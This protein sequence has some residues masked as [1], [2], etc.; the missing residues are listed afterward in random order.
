M[1]GG[2]MGRKQLA[3]LATAKPATKEPEAPKTWG[4]RV[5][6]NFNKHTAI[7]VAEKLFKNSSPKNSLIICM[8]ASGLAVSEISPGT[9]EREWQVIPDYPPHLAAARYLSSTKN[10]SIDPGALFYLRRI[11]MQYIFDKT[12]GT[13]HVG[14]AKEIKV[15]FGALPEDQRLG[16]VII[17]KSAEELKTLSLSAL[18]ALYNSVVEEDQAVQ[19]FSKKDDRT[20]QRVWD[21]VE[22][23]Y[24]PKVQAQAEKAAAAAA[25]AEAMASTAAEKGAA[26]GAKKEAGAPS[27]GA[28]REGTKM[29]NLVAKLQEGG[30]CTLEELSEASGYDLNNTRTAIGILRSKKGMPINYDRATKLYSLVE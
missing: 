15:A 23:N 13:V 21:A 29:G 6:I 3:A 10:I 20:V 7:E 1:S 30:E 22:L 14:N 25:K 8:D 9:L 17:V 24:D 28:P 11:I 18:A 2:V 19:K 27:T 12:S 5:L 26:K 4:P 16:G